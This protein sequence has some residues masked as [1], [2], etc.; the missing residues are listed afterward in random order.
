MEK[1]KAKPSV[2]KAFRL[3]DFHFYDD[4]TKGTVESDSN[5][6]SDGDKS[7]KYW[8]ANF[9]IQMFGINEKGETCCVYV[10]D[11]KP[12]FYVKVGKNWD[13]YQANMLK[14]FLS[15]KVSNYYSK[16]LL[17]C[18]IVDHYKL[19]GFS[20]GNKSKFVML[21]FDSISSMNKYKY[22][23]TDRL[24]TLLKELDLSLSGTH[25]KD[26]YL[27]HYIEEILYKRGV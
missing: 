3:I 26:V 20:G 9:V 14:Q 22:W 17:E 12:F 19:Y 25:V 4:S 10:N 7:K 16:G 8:D 2:L 15:Q 6:E 27:R 1:K 5:S 23:S 18:K 11:Y 21:T 24:L 13:Q